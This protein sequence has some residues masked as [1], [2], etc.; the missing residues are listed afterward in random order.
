MMRGWKLLVELRFEPNREY[1]ALN[2]PDDEGVAVN[3]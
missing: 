1:G 3:T 2:S